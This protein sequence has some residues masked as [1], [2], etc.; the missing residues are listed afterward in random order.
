MQAPIGAGL[1]IA[2]LPDK[3]LTTSQK[4]TDAVVDTGL[5]TLNTP[6]AMANALGRELKRSKNTNQLKGN[7]KIKPQ[8]TKT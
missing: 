6:L 4:M 1:T 7:I 3:R 2:A 8:E 5:F